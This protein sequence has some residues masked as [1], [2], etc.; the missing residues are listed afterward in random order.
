MQIG[1]WGTYDFTGL[2]NCSLLKVVA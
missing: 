2:T 1:Y